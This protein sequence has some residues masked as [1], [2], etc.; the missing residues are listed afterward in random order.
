MA[1]VRVS[2][3]H[4][5]LGELIIPL[6]LSFLVCKIGKMIVAVSLF[7]LNEFRFAKHLK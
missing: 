3:F 5:F 6:C 1:E 2:H 4:D 7:C